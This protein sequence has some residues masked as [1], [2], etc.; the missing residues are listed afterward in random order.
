MSFISSLVICK[1]N[2]VPNSK[3]VYSQSVHA[4]ST[5]A[6]G[7]E[8]HEATTEDILLQPLTSILFTPE[9]LV[10]AALGS[11]TISSRWDFHTSPDPIW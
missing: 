1:D 10:G 3:Q 9:F 4:L 6:V 8:R 2:R 7:V 5:A 11:K